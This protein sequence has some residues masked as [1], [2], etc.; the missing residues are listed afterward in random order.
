MILRFGRL[1]V[2]CR[3]AVDVNDVQLFGFIY[4]APMAELADAYGSGPYEG[5]FMEVQV[6]L[7]APN[8]VTLE[9]F[10]VV[11]LIVLT[12]KVYLC[13]QSCRKKGDAL[14]ISL[15]VFIFVCKLI[16]FKLFQTKPQ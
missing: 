2:R 10:F 5:N 3:M 4:H 8:N 12:S 13:F 7:G 15:F 14:C 9:S 6:L 16:G 11:F 1:L